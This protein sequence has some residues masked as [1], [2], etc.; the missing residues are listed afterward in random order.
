MNHLQKG[1]LQIKISKHAYN[2]SKS[3]DLGNQDSISSLTSSSLHYKDEVRK[4][5][6]DVMGSGS[7]LNLKSVTMERNQQQMI[8]ILHQRL[9][10]LAN[11]AA[12]R[13]IMCAEDVNP[14][15]NTVS[16]HNKILDE[17]EENMSSKAFQPS[18]NR[19]ANLVTAE[20]IV[21]DPIKLVLKTKVSTEASKRLEMKLEDEFGLPN[22]RDTKHKRP[23]GMHTF[24]YRYLHMK[25]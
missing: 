16:I 20:G 19:T 8:G 23:K 4:L 7:E 14:Y 15:S 24:F 11:A 2:I 22:M 6:E 13:H 10:A 18:G 21:L 9:A 5:E 1:N 25:F 3:I 17:Y 12:Q